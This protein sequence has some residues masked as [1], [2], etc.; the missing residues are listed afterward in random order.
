M[1]KNL[2]HWTIAQA[3][4]PRAPYLLGAIAFAESSFFPLPPDVLLAPMA[5]SRPK[6]AWFYALICTI[7]S[8]LGGILGYAI[9]ALL[10][11]SVALPVLQFY[12]LA[13]KVEPL[14]ACYAQWGWLVILLK[15]FTPIPFKIVTIGTG[16]LGYSF[17]MFVLM[18]I[19]TRGA[20]FFVLAAIFNRFGEPLKAALEKHFALLTLS[21]LVTI[22]LGVWL[23]IRFG[24]S[25]CG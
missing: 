25:L 15:G 7:A 8:V 21:I 16:I 2:Y 18:S 20:R 22:V 4:S 11:E 12:H 9:G 17:G 1:F 24:G 6:S 13:D 23:V 10:Y 3:A 5:L 14:R 19:I